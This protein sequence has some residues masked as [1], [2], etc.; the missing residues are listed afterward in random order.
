MTRMITIF[1]QE[2]RLARRN[3]WVLL[4][5]GVLTLFAL[6]LAFL[7]AG[8]GAALKADVL[9]LTAAS[10]A[11]LSVYLIPLIAL[12]MSYDAFSGEVER[13][14]LAL[15]LATPVRRW[16]LFGAKFLAQTVAAGTA[17]AISF[18]LAGAAVVLVYGAAPAGLAA[19]ASLTA[20]SIALGAVFVAVGLTLSAAAGRT[21]LAA[22]MAIGIW[23]VLVVLYD[24]ALLG[25]IMAAG[26]GVF[27]SHV[28]PWLVLANPAD[29]FRLYN[30]AA[31]DAAPVA[32]IDG[33]ARTLPFPPYAALGALAL[34]LAGAL[35]LGIHRT[36]RIVL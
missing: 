13:G 17:I 19:W 15:T 21:A 28:F 12:L 36:K 26:E 25:G 1:V 6:A 9:S 35:A 16:E 18:L 10:L 14:T 4:A 2:F 33:L 3:L 32:G 11:T 8:Q 22:A 20:S 30:L 23:L 24:L 31:L 34:W 5:T 7:G 27:A 29:A